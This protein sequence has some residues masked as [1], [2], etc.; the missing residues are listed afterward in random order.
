MPCKWFLRPLGCIKGSACTNKHDP[1][2]KR[3]ELGSEHKLI[4]GCGCTTAADRPCRHEPKLAIPKEWKLAA[5]KT[6][7]KPKQ[8]SQPKVKKQLAEMS[9]A[10]TEMRAEM[11]KA[12]QARESRDAKLKEEFASAVAAGLEEFAQR[13]SPPA[14]GKKKPKQ[15]PVLVRRTQRVR[16]S[17]ERPVLSDSGCTWTMEPESSKPADKRGLTKVDADGAFGA[18]HT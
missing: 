17:S 2:A 15:K 12:E 11:A 14:D 1:E 8:Q 9:Q 13:E 10:L 18:E 3:K 7:T 5:A 16:S 6:E 4:C